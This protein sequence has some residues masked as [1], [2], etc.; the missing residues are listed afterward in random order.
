MDASKKKAMIE[1]NLRKE[2]AMAIITLNK[3]CKSL[4]VSELKA[5]IHWEKRKADK[6]VPSG[7]PALQERYTNTIIRADIPLDIFLTDSGY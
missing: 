6:S 4:T 3:Q 7:K 5:I 2:E 1:Y